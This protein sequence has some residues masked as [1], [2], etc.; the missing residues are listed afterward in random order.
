MSIDKI[1]IVCI[2]VGQLISCNSIENSQ[3]AGTFVIKND[4]V[5]LYS[6]SENLKSLVALSEVSVQ[7]EQLEIITA[8]RI[9][10]IPTQFAYVASPFAGRINRC[11]VK[12]GQKVTENMPLFEIVSPEFTAMQKE[13]FLAEAKREVARKDLLR[14]KELLNNGVG[15]VKEYE[16]ALSTMKQA[17]KEYENTQAS[18]RTYHVDPEKMIL[19]DPLI[20]RA[21]ISGSIIENN[22]VTGQYINSDADPVA[23]VANLSDVWVSAQVKE[24]DIRFIDK[25]DNMNIYVDALPGKTITGRVAHINDK[26]DEETR[27]IH[28]ISVSENQNEELKI[29]MYATMHF[30][31]RP[32]DYM[33]VPEKAVLQGEKNSYVLLYSSPDYLIRQAVKIEFTK[34]GYAYISKGIQEGETIVSEGGY[35][36]Q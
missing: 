34:G 24:K 22:I 8:G 16:E 23:L 27:S 29:G 19:G 30:Y 17:D 6:F 2:L 1:I 15:S 32:I 36:F 12:L 25:G 20:V 31:G 11:Y 21:P 33:V 26:V 35:Y 10:A 4:T 5:F 28:V 7:S 9:Q 13:Y 3:D 18:L 14:K